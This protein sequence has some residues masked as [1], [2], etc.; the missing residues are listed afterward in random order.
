LY[1]TTEAYASKFKAQVAS[2]EAAGFMTTD[3]G[4]LAESNAQAG[5]GPLQQPTFLIP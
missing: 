4:Q 2:T 3:D 5:I 1:P